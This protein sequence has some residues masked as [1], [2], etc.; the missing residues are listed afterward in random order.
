MRFLKKITPYLWITPAFALMMSVVAFPLIQNT[1]RS[2]YARHGEN[3]LFVRFDNYRALFSDPNFYHSIWLTVI[4]TLFVTSFQFLIG[5]LVA[6]LINVKIRSINFL[7]PMLILPWALPGIVAA[8]TWVFMYSERGLIN[9]LLKIFVH[10]PPVW[11]AEK[12][13]AMFAVIVAAIWKGFPFYMLMLLAGLQAVPK[14]M[15][16]AAKI[17]GARPVRVLW[18]ISL[19]QMSSV[20]VTSLIL[21]VIWT[22]NYFD[23]IFLMTGGGPAKATQT[24]PIWI[25]KIAFSQFNIERAAA[26]SVILLLFVLAIMAIHLRLNRKE[27]RL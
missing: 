11:L 24:L 17:D 19:P 3:Y 27:Y 12:N 9:Q 1:I 21:G 13:W 7:K 18:N 26:L 22:S 15:I 20:I 4:W 5:L 2:F 25:Y 10:D 23:G 6:L 14:D 8:T 16:E